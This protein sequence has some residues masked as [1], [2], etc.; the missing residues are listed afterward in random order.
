MVCLAGIGRAE[1]R[2]NGGAVVW[3]KI[4]IAFH[5]LCIKIDPIRTGQELSA[6]LSLLK[7]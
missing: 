5:S 3:W 7:E 1:H 6:L 4:K 2:R